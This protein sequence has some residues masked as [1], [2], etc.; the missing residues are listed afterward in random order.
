MSSVKGRSQANKGRKPAAVEPQDVPKLLNVGYGN[1]LVAAR[2][3]AV[4]EGR[5]WIS[6]NL[7]T[8]PPAEYTDALERG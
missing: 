5:A 4:V 8:I 2:V 7:G 3:V 1:V 6:V